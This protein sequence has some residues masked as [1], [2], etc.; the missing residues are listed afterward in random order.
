M[1]K[2]EKRAYPLSK[3][4]RIKQLLWHVLCHSSIFLGVDSQIL[5]IWTITLIFYH[6]YNKWAM[7][8]SKLVLLITHKGDRVSYKALS[9]NTTLLNPHNMRYDEPWTRGSWL[10]FSC[11]FSCISNFGNY[12]CL[13]RKYHP[14]H[15]YDGE[16]AYEHRLHNLEAGTRMRYKTEWKVSRE[17]VNIFLHG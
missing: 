9:W 8:E 3:N 1:Q 11:N 2:G 6:C 7:G 12:S 14:R 17:V 15:S 16:L 4:R 13:P 5:M 10:N